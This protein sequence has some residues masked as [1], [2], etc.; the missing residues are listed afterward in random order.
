ME[1]GYR[2]PMTFKKL[3]TIPSLKLTNRVADLKYL[4]DNNENEHVHQYVHELME[5]KDPCKSEWFN[6]AYPERSI[7]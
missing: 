5:G 6:R 2:D 3:A 7:S 4:I 1:L